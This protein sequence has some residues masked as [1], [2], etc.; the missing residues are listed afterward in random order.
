MEKPNIDPQSVDLLNLSTH[1][2]PTLCTSAAA[3]IDS[4]ALL[5]DEGKVIIQHQGEQYQLRQTKSGKL[6]LTK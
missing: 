3:T 1:Q 5:G 2:S 6:I 4:H